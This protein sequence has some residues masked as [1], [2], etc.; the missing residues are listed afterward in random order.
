MP[1]RQY[2][3]H[4]IYKTVCLVTEK[5]YVGMHSTSDLED[6]Y[7]GSGKVLKRSLNKYGRQNHTL[8]ILERLEDRSSLKNREK[9]IVNE[10][11]L[12]DPMNMNLQLGG[13]GG[14]CSD[15]HEAR[16]HKGQAKYLKKA[17]KDPEYMNAHKKRNS[18]RF[19]K[20]HKEG[21]IST[22]TFEDRSHSIETKKKM[23]ESHIGKHDGI[24][25]SQYGTKWIIHQELGIK[26]IK[27]EEITYYLALGWRIGRK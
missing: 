24:K 20:L 1:R 18:D 17:W 3:Y 22:N 19:K 27:K 13:G 8:E 7:L 10:D 5:Y 25:N 26:K 14:F 21:K 9:E 4:Y 15:E 12:N 11:L 6:G 2:K 16:F 23:C